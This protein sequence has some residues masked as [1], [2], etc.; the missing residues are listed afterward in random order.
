MNKRVWVMRALLGVLL[1]AGLAALA[2]FVLIPLFYTGTQG[3]NGAIRVYGYSEGEKVY[4]L[5]NDRLLFALD[6]ATTHFT[7]TQKDNGHVWYSNPPKADSDPL[8]L[9]AD[10]ANL[11]S[12][13]SIVFSTVN[14]VNTLFNNYTYSIEKGIYEIE[15]G[16][17][18]I[19]VK[20]SLGKV[21]KTFMIPI[22]ITEARLNAFLAKMEKNESKQT[23]EYYRK[24]DIGKLR[25]TDNKEELLKNYPD[26]NTEPV[27]ILR[28]G[29]ADYLK[30]RV[31]GFFE[32]A[33]YTFEDYNFDMS[34][35]SASSATDKPVFNVALLYRL[36]GGDLVVDVPYE[37]IEYKASYPITKLT[38]LPNFGA[39]GTADDGFMLVP[40]GG[41]ALIR[42][43]NG[44]LAQ[45][46]YY[47]NIYGWDYAT[48]RKTVVSETRSAFPV[49][50]VSLN[51]SA[52]LCIME[53]G[54]GSAG[55]A[56]D[57]SG[58]YNSYNT[59]SATYTLLHSDFF[60]VTNKSNQPV[61]VYESSLPQGFIR[62]RY[63]F[64]ATRGYVAMA[65]AYQ[66]YLLEKY[67]SLALEEDAFPPVLIEIVGAVDKMLQRVGLP[68]SVPYKLTTHQEAR[69]MLTALSEAGIKNLSVKY[70]GF[71]N[72]GIRQKVL[73]K[74]TLLPD[75][76]SEADF[77]CLT[78]YCN[79][80][81][82]DLYL[83][84]VVQFAYDSGPLDG[85]MAF[86]DAAKYTTREEVE[87]RE[88]STIWY[89]TDPLDTPYFLVKPAL[90]P[91]YTQ[92]LAQAAGKYGARGVS[93]R[94]MGFLLSS[95]FNPKEPV[96][97]DQNMMKQQSAL[98]AVKA[99]GQKILINAGNDYALAYADLVSNMDLRGSPYSILD[100]HVPFYQMALHGYVRYTGEALNMAGDF[101]EELLN[102]AETGAG[103]SFTFIKAEASILQDTLYTQYHGASFS[104]WFE[105]AKDI[106][107]KYDEE[108]GGLFDQ[109]IVSHE[110]LD[111]K[112]TITTY[113]DGTKVYV[114]Y[115]GQQAVVDGVVLAPRSYKAK[116]VK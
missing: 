73:N 75:L 67:P 98:K 66:K 17:G 60:D 16:D 10:K 33:G 27:Y 54:A 21:N 15:P 34:R 110:R 3:D 29:T 18:F 102:S 115:G 30:K 108:L 68:T 116:G 12:T 69:E 105:K 9:P 42:F 95:D 78:E 32:K 62:Q 80:N 72:G 24:Y 22:A 91:I 76:G 99:G 83:D 82:M 81:G 58:R 56:A 39:G 104:Q 7:V 2:V 6:P 97:R 26:L 111:N 35:T 47:S 79:D 101:E 14:G 36:E 11:M 55:V 70:A 50:G 31:E 51:D 87:L 64:A 8:A 1:L 112:V 92:T 90:V 103:L 4:T 44:K 20:Y 85:F 65:S 46:T 107:Q 59:I 61:L 94:D 74:A 77:L 45:N 89:G 57:I 5:E 41:G 86:R 49:F 109:P 71:F 53:D 114:N 37:E 40:E 93:F 113:R 13:L 63:R 100:E 106:C 84:G 25:A 43:N 38:L 52:F 88:Y 48:T 19:K 28:D 96:T 23:K